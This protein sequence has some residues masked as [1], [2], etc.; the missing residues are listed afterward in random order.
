MGIRLYFLNVFVLPLTMSRQDEFKQ[1]LNKFVKVR[2]SDGD[3]ISVAR[4]VFVRENAKFL[5][6]KGDISEICI[7]KDDIRKITSQGKNNDK[8]TKS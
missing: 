8:V 6:L 3:R 7:L 2:Y 4:G 1:F 5:F